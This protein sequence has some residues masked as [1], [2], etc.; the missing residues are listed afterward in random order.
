M[1][2]ETK[3]CKIN[4]VWLAGWPW[5]WRG[6]IS[7]DDAARVGCP[8]GIAARCGVWL[9][10]VHDDEGFWV[11]GVFSPILDNEEKGCKPLR[12]CAPRE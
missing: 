4:D 11:N 8:Q 5:S 2:N 7:F 3:E 1:V 9:S 10:R 12:Y 6:R